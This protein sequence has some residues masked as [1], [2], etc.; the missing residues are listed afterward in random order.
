M[1]N[2]SL[3][4]KTHKGGLEAMGTQEIQASALGPRGEWIEFESTGV[5]SNGQGH[6][7]G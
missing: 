6:S 2:A 3:R 1:Q 7:H 4:E 5:D